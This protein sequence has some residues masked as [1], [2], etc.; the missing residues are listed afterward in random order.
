MMQKQRAIPG[1]MPQLLE[2][3]EP[4]TFDESFMQQSFVARAELDTYEKT[5]KANCDVPNEE[6][7]R[8]IPFDRG[9]R[10]SVRKLMCHHFTNLEYHNAQVCYIHTLYG[11]KSM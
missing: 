4:P 2:T 7:D 10:W 6:L 1:P 9:Q 5:K 11:D 8:E 3:F